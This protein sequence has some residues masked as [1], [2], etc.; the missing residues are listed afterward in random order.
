[1]K[2]GR[3]EG[4]K[5][6]AAESAAGWGRWTKIIREKMNEV[7]HFILQTCTCPTMHCNE[8]PLPWQIFPQILLTL[9]AG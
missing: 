1:M 7:L 6:V 5:G 9:L 8:K 2:E 3:K 4:R